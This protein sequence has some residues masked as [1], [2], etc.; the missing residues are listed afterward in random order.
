MN[1]I[2][3]NRI[4]EENTKNEDFTTYLTVEAKEP[5]ISKDS[6]SPSSVENSVLE[7][8]G[9]PSSSLKFMNDILKSTKYWTNDL[10]REEE[11]NP[12]HLEMKL[13]AKYKNTDEVSI[14][15]DMGDSYME[16]TNAGNW[17]RN[18]EN[19]SS[20]QS[21]SNTS[22]CER[23]YTSQRTETDGPIFKL[24]NLEDYLKDIEGA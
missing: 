15:E 10:Q 21:L 4:L 12:E 6:A 3:P 23:E 9:D 7:L 17:V 1:P 8:S 5:L 16:N 22:G 11:P 19:L 18:Q 20:I 24:D 14:S 2:K 13:E